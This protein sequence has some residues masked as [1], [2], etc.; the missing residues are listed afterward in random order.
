MD[1]ICDTTD[2]MLEI[3]RQ[4]DAY[5]L[6]NLCAASRRLRDA[7]DND[8]FFEQVARQAYSDEFWRR[9]SLRTQTPCPTIR[10]ELVR[11]E[12]F[13]RML[14]RHDG[15]RWDEAKFFAMWESEA[16]LRVPRRAELAAEK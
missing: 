16:R 11:I 6:S 12:R 7:C 10:L 2:L 15:T 5:D 9:A 1:N 14:M 4:L 3:A 13:Q 8:A